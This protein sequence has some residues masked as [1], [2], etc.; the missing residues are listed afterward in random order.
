[1]RRLTLSALLAA[2]LAVVALAAGP[3]TAP[4]GSIDNPKQV[5]SA[6]RGPDVDPAKLAA[7]PFGGL[8]LFRTFRSFTSG[9][10]AAADV[11]V[12]ADKD[13]PALY[14]ANVGYDYP[15]FYKPTWGEVFDHVARQMRCSW[16]FDS[17]NRQFKFTPSS[18]EP[19]FTVTLARGWRREDRGPYVWFA[20]A[21]R[22]FGMDVYDYGHVT[23]D[24]AQPDLFQRVRE[25]FAML[26]VGSW[27]NPPTVA[28]MTTVKVA[29]A[30]ALYLR[31]DTPRPGGVWR[32]WAVVA[33]DHVFLIVSAM[34]KDDEKATGPAVDKMVASFAA[35]KATTGPTTR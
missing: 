7:S 17:H 20:P 4:V 18:D 10:Y 11:W 1:M 23:P 9:S 8:P 13:D 6:D 33:G 19:P 15:P 24:P 21:N 34:P 29:G 16:A 28:D 31:R 5:T 2:A 12:Y 25:H 32:Q 35:T 30:D 27:P 3:T 26:D 14:D 22:E